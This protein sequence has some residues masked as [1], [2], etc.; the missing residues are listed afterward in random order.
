MTTI[1]TDGKSMAADGLTTFNGMI[2]QDATKKVNRLGDGRIVGCCG[3]CS[4]ARLF[5]EWLL[6][7]GKAPKLAQGFGALVVSL[8][9][10]VRVYFHDCSYQEVEPPYA[11]GS[12]AEF[13]FAA[14]DCGKSPVGAVEIAARRDA[15]T[16][17]VITEMHL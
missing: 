17:G 3:D 5:A 10:P 2:V 1:A 9:E 12:G 15:K 13:A 6:A 16:G 4:D 7:G 14:M 11:I 8:L